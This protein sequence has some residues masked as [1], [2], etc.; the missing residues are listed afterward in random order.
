[1]RHMKMTTGICWAFDTAG[2]GN[3]SGFQRRRTTPIST[4]KEP[5]S[6]EKYFE[7]LSEFQILFLF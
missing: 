7:K 4:K 2:S 6:L 5:M 1:V 3:L